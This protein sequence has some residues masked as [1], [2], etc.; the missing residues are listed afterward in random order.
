MPRRLLT[1]SVATV[2]GGTGVALGAPTAQAASSSVVVAEV[3]GGGGNAGAPLLSD[4]VEL[5]NRGSSSVD[6]TGWQLRY[7]SASGTTPTTTTIGGGTIAAGG[8]FLVKQAS[9]ANAAGTAAPLPTPD[10]TGTVTMSATTG[11]V[12][13]VD[14][15]GSVV[16]LLGWGSSAATFEVA[17]AGGTS[18][19]TSVART[20]PCLDTDD[21]AADFTVGAP[22]PQNSTAPAIV[23][24]VTPPP[25]PDPVETIAQIQGAAHVSPLAG[26]KV[27]GVAGVVTAVT[28]NGFWMQDP[29][30]DGDPATS[31]GVFVF[32]RTA[33]TVAAGNAVTVDATVSEFR[34]GGT[35]G[36]AN[37]TTTQLLSP[38]VTV[39]G[40]SVPLPTPVVIGV[41]RV[42][43]QQV[44]DAENPGS[45]ETGGA[46][47]PD[48]DAIDFSESLEGMRVAVRDAQVVGPT[49]AF[50][51]I[52]VLPGQAVS[53]LRSS[54][55]GVVYGSYAMPNSMRVQLDDALLP[56][57]SM[58]AANVGDTLPG[59][60]T[61]VLDYSFANYKLLVTAV[62][63]VR[64]GG[65]TR[66]I[67]TAQ[68]T[69]Q[70]AV[71][72]F[73][74]ENL[75]PS[76]PQSKFDALATQVVVNLAAPDILA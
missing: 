56:T 41:D 68:T 8:R 71:A 70:L 31:E 9:G 57:G 40:P 5:F 75:S 35:G 61:G 44:I 74:V 27:N 50:G 51:E 39:V 14:P 66:E 16:D 76:N 11:R 54:A 37:L 46:F 24:T 20:D 18:N 33:P 1:L 36:L 10:A 19:S 58:P 23:C 30:G 28:R 59:D 7:W 13:V 12:A 55:G 42:A 21:N 22:T 38:V 69:N 17:P 29:I 52:P 60:T 43:P 62:P 45:V 4:Y 63:V 48:R 64:P 3:Y 26:G 65:L 47:R 49:A 34:P 32:T 2:V 25:P 73:N 15:S 53:P 72:T 67:T 6:L